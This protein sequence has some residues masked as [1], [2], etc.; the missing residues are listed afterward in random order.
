MTEYHNKDTH[1]SIVWE[2]IIDNNKI[3]GLIPIMV[4]NGWAYLNLLENS[5]QFQ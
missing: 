5:I 1:K 3:I 4:A 2:T